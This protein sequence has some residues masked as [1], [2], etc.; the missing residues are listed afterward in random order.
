MQRIRAL[1]LAMCAGCAAPPAQPPAPRPAAVFSTGRV[2]SADATTTDIALASAD[3]AFP[4]VWVDIGLDLRALP[5]NS[6]ADH[7]DL[8]VLG[9][10]DRLRNMAPPG[11][12]VE[13]RHMPGAG[14]LYVVFRAATVS[15][16]RAACD[17]T[18][19]VY[20]ADP[21]RLPILTSHGKPLPAAHITEPCHD[22]VPP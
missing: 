4:A 19:A 2:A 13:I 10:G 5:A 12:D 18:V 9:E 16:A 21:P 6:S 20:F 8:F 22:G 15:T 17:R 7:V 14:V 1:S 11:V 3:A